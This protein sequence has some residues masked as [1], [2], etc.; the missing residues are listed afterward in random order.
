LNLAFPAKLRYAEAMFMNEFFIVFPEGD[1]QEVSGRI[2]LNELVDVNGRE[3]ELPLA[4]NK[5]IVFRV[6]RVKVEENKGGNETFHFLE[7]MSAEE[8]LAYTA[9]N[10]AGRV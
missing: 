4:T 3:L 6:A 10:Y 5:M 2:S 1:I 9:A 8:L 7:L